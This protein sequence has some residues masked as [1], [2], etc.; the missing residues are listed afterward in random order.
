ME[1]NRIGIKR[2]KRVVKKKTK[3]VEEML[4]VEKKDEWDEK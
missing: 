1:A 4:V 3:L 2:M